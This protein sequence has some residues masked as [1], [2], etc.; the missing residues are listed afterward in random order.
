MMKYSNVHLVLTG[1]VM[2]EIN[3]LSLLLHFKTFIM[4]AL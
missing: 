1:G 4:Y 3:I 2:L